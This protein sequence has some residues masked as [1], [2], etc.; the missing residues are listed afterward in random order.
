ML[1][2]VV[3]GQSKV[4]SKVTNDKSHESPSATACRT[5]GGDSMRRDS[6]RAPLLDTSRPFVDETERAFHG[7]FESLEWRV[8]KV[9][10]VK[11]GVV[12]F[13]YHFVGTLHEG[14][15]AVESWGQEYV[16]VHGGFIQH[17]EIR[18]VQVPA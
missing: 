3:A 1:V 4:R 8:R 13:E 17:I 12:L 7:R 5:F 2:V 6:G 9:E 14:D 18:N 11:P 15:P 16:I 10:E